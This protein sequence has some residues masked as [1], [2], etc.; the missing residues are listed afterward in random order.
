MSEAQTFLLKIANDMNKTEADFAKYLEALDENMLDTIDS[1]REVDDEQW[2]N[3]LKFPVG[4]INKVKKYL[5]EVGGPVVGQ[6]AQMKPAP[7]E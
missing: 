6:A 3:D 2:R 7:V 5:A 4:L 1:L